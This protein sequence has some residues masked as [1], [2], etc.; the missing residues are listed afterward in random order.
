MRLLSRQSSMLFVATLATA[1]AASTFVA[2]AASAGGSG[3][4]ASNA[5]VLASVKAAQSVTKVPSGLKPVLTNENDIEVLNNGEC[6]AH[7]SAPKVGIDYL[8]FGQC[9]YG[10]PTGKRLLVIFGDSHAGMWLTAIRYAAARAGWRV[11]IFYFPGCPAPD[12]TFYSQTSNAP[13]LG[14]NK[15]RTDA[16]AAMRKLHPA[17]LV[18]TSATLSQEV[19]KGV[20]ATSAQWETGLS[21]TLSMLKMPGTQLAVIGDIPVLAEDD[22]TCLAA[23]ESN[24]KACTTPIAQAETGVYNAAE[25]Q[26]AAATG[27]NYIPTSQWMCAQLCVPIVGH[28]RVYN[29]QFHISA[30]YAEYLSGAVQSAL[31]L[32][33][34]L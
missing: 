12:L 15:F 16:I 28:I 6:P 3:S 17:M 2:G 33:G 19:S 10:D 9:T 20:T 22:A 4:V 1:L 32:G 13:N 34:T 8:H 5:Q 25:E 7:Y 24:V 29:N 18:V 26:A 31:G 14:C 23:H 27:A 11:R 21:K 30:T